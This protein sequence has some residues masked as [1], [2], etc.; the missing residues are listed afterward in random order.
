LF[1][2]G[3]ATTAFRSTVRV[4]LAAFALGLL[5]AA[6]APADEAVTRELAK[7]QGTWMP[8]AITV[9]GVQLEDEERKGMSVIQKGEKVTLLFKDKERGSGT[10]KIDPSKHPAA[11]DFTYE[12]GPAKGVTLK[13]IYKVEG[14][15]RTLCLGGIGK[16]RPTEFASKAGSGTMLWVEKKAK[17]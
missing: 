3:R 7:L 2:A 14:D 13:G 15:T 5:A 1:A 9:D 16:D 8:V 17:P 12:D 4:S 10:M 11:L 6:A